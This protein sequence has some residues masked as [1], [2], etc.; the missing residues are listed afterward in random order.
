MP[1]IADLLKTAIQHHRS[2]QVAVAAQLYQEVLQQQPDQ[3]NALYLLGLIAHQANNLETA[4][5]YYQQA[6]AAQTDYA[7][8]HNNLGAALQ[9]QGNLVAAA[10]HYHAALRIAPNNPSANINLGVILQQQGN[11]EAAIARYQKAIRL[12]QNLPEAYTNLGYALKE[13]GDLGGAIEHYQTAL[14]RGL[15]TPDIYRELGDALQE[16]GSIDDAI[17][18]FDQAV[19]QFPDHMRLRGSRIRAKLIAGKLAEGFAE[20]DPWRLHLAGKP[21][22]FSQP[23]WD[24]ADLTGKTILLYTEPGAGIGDTLQFMRYAPMVVQRGG[25][26]IVECYPSLRR[27]CQSITGIDTVVAVGEPLPDFDV[28]ASLLS[29]PYIFK[30]TLATI[31]V[32][33]PYVSGTTADVAALALPLPATSHPLHRVG[34]VWGGDPNHLHDRERSCPVHEFRRFLAI[35][36]IAYYSLQKGAHAAELSQIQDL[37]VVD[38]GDRLHDFADTAAIVAQLDLVITVDTSVA[39]LVGAMGKPVWM[40]LSFAADWRWLMHRDDSP[41][42]PTAKLFRQSRRHA[43]ADVCDRLAQELKQFKTLPEQG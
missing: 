30:T 18:L 6:V 13:K 8:A 3:P 14:N 9:Q 26:V 11:V 40:L 5:A 12:D 31:P 23:V 41:W 15:R 34:I 28:Q 19:C 39:H 32:N 7:D 43:W 25:R 42:Y 36:S 33:I 17:A 37:P 22:D 2:G 21:R 38:L 35:G 20:Y 24:G 29:L 4:I 10:N 27:L 1:P 16:A